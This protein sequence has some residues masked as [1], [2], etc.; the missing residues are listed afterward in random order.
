[1][2]VGGVGSSGTNAWI[3]PGPKGDMPRTIPSRSELVSPFHCWESRL[4]EGRKALPKA[5]STR[6]KMSKS[7][8]Q[9]VRQQAGTRGVGK[10]IDD[11]RC[12]AASL[13][14]EGYACKAWGG[15]AAR[16]SALPVPGVR[17][18][19][20][21]ITVAGGIRM[22]ASKVSLKGGLSS[23]GSGWCP[24]LSL[25]CQIFLYPHRGGPG[26]LNGE[27]G[28]MLAALCPRDIPQPHLLLGMDRVKHKS[29][30]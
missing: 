10:G 17:E 12:Q 30:N 26:I 6:G 19:G 18:G 5:L 22:V 8:E 11:Q 25:F 23:S 27:V 28:E 21:H 29:H 16:A 4:R 1:M 9:Q 14:A 2:D 15:A 3:S 24:V 20:V 7:V 13:K